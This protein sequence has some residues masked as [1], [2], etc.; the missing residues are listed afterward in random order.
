MARLRNVSVGWKLTIEA[1]ILYG[2]SIRQRANGAN[3]GGL[4]YECRFTTMAAAYSGLCTMV[5]A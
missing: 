3:D 4:A 2:V 1:L 5:V